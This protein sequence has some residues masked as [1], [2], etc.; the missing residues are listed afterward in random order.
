MKIPRTWMLLAATLALPS[1]PAA[2]QMDLEFERERM[3]T[4]HDTVV[5]EIEKKFYDPKLRGLDWKTLTAVT[6]S[7]IDR[8][9]T[10]DEMLT[11]LFAQVEQLNDSHTVFIPPGRR[12]QVLFGFEAK[13]FGNEVR[14]YEL[15]KDSAAAAAGLRRGDR[16]LQVNGFKA[17]R[18]SFDQ[19]MLL[20][21]VLQPV[22]EM[23]IVYRRGEEPPQRV[24]V[25]AKI[26]RG[27]QVTDLTDIES[28]YQLIREAQSEEEKFH[29][30]ILEAGIGYVQLPEFSGDEEFIAGLV[31]KVSKAGAM[32]VDLRG[33][34]GGTTNALTAFSGH[35]ENQPGVMAD[36]LRRN[37]S[38]AIKLKPRNPALAGPMF[39][40]VDSDSAS[41]A[42]MFA[43]HFQR[44][45]R[46]VVIGDRTAGRVTASRIFP[47]MMGVD[48]VWLYAI[49]VAVGRV[50]FPGGE[51][52]EGR[53][54]T[55]DH[56]CIPTGEQL[57][58][59][60]DPCRA[61][62]I[63]FARKALGIPE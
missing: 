30:S 49:Q 28:I 48:T 47:Q 59:G 9:Q 24:R 57:R 33:N 14:I 12:D 29:H 17:E 13:A 53:G 34:P 52:L 3:R 43:R 5:T 42:E 41:A 44:T 46:A 55:P 32:I 50:V 61:L 25:Q 27:R 19:L 60:Q 38:D 22:Q 7:R 37:K 39:I 21:R 10:L 40:L 31:K 36:V 18:A 51:E 16:L 20:L 45:G 54:V 15:K 2:A 58:E 26:K 23:D 1:L 4:V 62:A 11:A 35:F 63:S 8:A 56:A 6:R